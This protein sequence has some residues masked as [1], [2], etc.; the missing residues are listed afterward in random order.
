MDIPPNLS[1][2]TTDEGKTEVRPPWDPVDR[3]KEVNVFS[4]VW[5]FR[6][7]NGVQCTD[8]V[9]TGRWGRDYESKD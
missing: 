6:A 7:T 9:N 4:S 8:T 5:V 2:V 1:C 3:I